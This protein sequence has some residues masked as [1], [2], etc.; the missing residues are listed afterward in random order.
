MSSPWP[1]STMALTSCGDTPAASPTKYWKRA[2]SSTPAMP[3]TRFLGNPVTLYIAYTIE[4]SGLVTTTTKALGAYCLMPWATLVMASRFTL[5]RSSRL[6]PGLRGTPAVNPLRKANVPLDQ[7]TF[8]RDR[9][10]VHVGDRLY[11]VR[12]AHG[13]HRDLHV[14]AG[15]RERPAQAAARRLQSTCIERHALG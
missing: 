10:E 2:V 11:R 15:K 5:S 13:E 4:S 9:R 14:A 1:P 3:T 7:G 12:I 8:S 6:M